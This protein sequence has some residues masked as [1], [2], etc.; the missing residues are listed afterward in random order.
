MM[1]EDN[2]MSDEP[3]EYPRYIDRAFSLAMMY[4]DAHWLTNLI[5]LRGKLR[6]PTC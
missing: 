3:Q 4:C 5:S 2:V 6:I 1:E